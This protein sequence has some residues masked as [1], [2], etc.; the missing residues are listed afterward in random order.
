MPSSIVASLHFYLPNAVLRLPL[1][2]L[3]HYLKDQAK[4]TNL[5]FVQGKG[6][7][8]AYRQRTV[9]LQW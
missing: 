4:T 7:Q 6:G 1:T 5:R 9:E 8:S 2:I 3:A